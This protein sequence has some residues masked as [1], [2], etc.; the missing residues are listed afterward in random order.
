MYIFGHIIYVH[1]ISHCYLKKHSLSNFGNSALRVELHV[2]Q[3]LA[4]LKLLRYFQLT[5]PPRRHNEANVRPRSCSV[6]LSLS[7]TRRGNTAV[8]RMRNEKD[9]I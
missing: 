4:A 9:A 7:H 1:A 6:R 5:L 8:S 2:Q 3:F